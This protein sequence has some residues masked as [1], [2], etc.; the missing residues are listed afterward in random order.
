MFFLSAIFFAATSFPISEELF[1]EELAMSEQLA[2]IEADDEAED[3][4]LIFDSDEI[5]AELDQDG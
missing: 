4:E 5:V 1:D 3:G 2:E